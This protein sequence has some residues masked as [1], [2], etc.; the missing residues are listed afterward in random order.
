MNAEEKKTFY[1][2]IG[3]DFYSSELTNGKN[4]GR[5]RAGQ[6]GYPYTEEPARLLQIAPVTACL[7][8]YA[9]R[10][11]RFGCILLEA[12][13]PRTEVEMKLESLDWK[14]TKSTAEI[15]YCKSRRFIS[16]ILS[17]KF[18]SNGMIRLS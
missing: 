1:F 7:G 6:D 11:V 10:P 18:H 5:K 12:S 15:V 14:V 13:P 4:V 17:M 9:G 2:Y 3:N 8:A 16:G